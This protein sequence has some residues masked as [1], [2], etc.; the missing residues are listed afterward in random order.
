MSTKCHNCKYIVYE[1]YNNNWCKSP[2]NMYYVLDMSTGKKLKK[3]HQSL[4]NIDKNTCSY[5]P[6]FSKK[7]SNILRYF[8]LKYY[9]YKEPELFLT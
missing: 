6:T 4:K 3:L 7:L 5:K 1:T 8:R 9:K 2:K